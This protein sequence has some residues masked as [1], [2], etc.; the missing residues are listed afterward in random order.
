M[1]QI[2][3]ILLIL[4]YACLAKSQT[5]DLSTQNWQIWPDASAQYENDRLFMPP[6]QPE[7]MEARPPS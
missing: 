7:Q 2:T 4:C 5:I 6:Y 3:L 1:K